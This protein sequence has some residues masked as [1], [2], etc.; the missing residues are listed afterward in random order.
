MT[1]LRDPAENFF[2]SWKYYN[3]L[4]R[5]MRVL[6]NRDLNGTLNLDLNQQWVTEIERFF[7]TPYKSRLL[8]FSWKSQI[9]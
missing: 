3:K 2:S 8:M 6:I 9:V 5:E 7:K 1:I 4:I